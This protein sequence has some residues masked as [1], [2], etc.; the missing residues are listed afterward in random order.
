MRYLL[1]VSIVFAAC[2]D[3]SAQQATPVLAVADQKLLDSLLQQF[4]V[5]PQGAQYV[6]VKTPYRTTWGTDE[7]IAREGWLV[8]A[9][10][11]KPAR[12][13]FADG[14]SIAAPKAIENLDFI[15]QCRKRYAAAEDPRIV[16]GHGMEVDPP[17]EEM[18]RTAVG[19]IEQLDLVLAAWLY[20][21]DQRELAA[22]ALARARRE[23]A[24]HGLW[25]CEEAPPKITI[26]DRM[27]RG[28]KKDLA[29]T[30]FAAMLRAYMVRADEEA[31]AHGERLL[32]LYPDIVK[33]D[34]AQ[35]DAVVGE[36]K[37]RKAKGAFGKAPPE[38][39]PEGF[40]SWEP[41]K[42]IAWLIDSLEEVDARP[43]IV[44]EPGGPGRP[45]LEVDRRVAALVEIGDAAVP[46]L[47]E[48]VEKDSR[49]TRSVDFCR[50]F[51]RTGMALGVR[52]AALAAVMS[53]L[54]VQIF[55]SASDDNFTCRGPECVAATVK[56]LRQYWQTNGGLPFDA[57]MMK[58]LTDPNASP[59]ARRLAAHN[60]ANPGDKQVLLIWPCVTSEEYYGWAVPRATQ[61]T[62]L[63][64]SSRSPALPKPCWPPWTPTVPARTSTWRIC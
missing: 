42:K 51:Q 26:E 18:G 35:A 55:E 8:S 36:L 31:L 50:D 39:R 24:E 38:K 21:L 22:K 14:D 7:E 20:R 25:G 49:L 62:P 40:D 19:R 4:L 59:A 23:V 30:A 48:A 12:V 60:L 54:Q 27:I 34:Y 41:K 29:C 63:W 2:S 61:R 3:A 10:N 5:D 58:I 56:R 17:F 46:A 13:C 15:D 32:R 9:T 43:G 33:A 53:I 45:L 44:L 6:R 47:I 11:G 64:P 1:A 52:E 57:R 37:R 16:D 28:M